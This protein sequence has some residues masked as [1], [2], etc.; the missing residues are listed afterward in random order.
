MEMVWTIIEIV[1]QWLYVIRKRQFRQK[2]IFKLLFFMLLVLCVSTIIHMSMKFFVRD[3]SWENFVNILAIIFFTISIFDLLNME[4]N[5]DAFIE[6]LLVYC[7]L[8]R[9]NQRTP[10]QLLKNII[11]GIMTI[12]LIYFM[13]Q[14]MNLIAVAMNLT[15]FEIAVVGLVIIYLVLYCLSTVGV[16]DEKSLY[17]NKAKISIALF[18]V[19]MIIYLMYMK[20]MSLNQNENIC[21]ILIFTIGQISFIQNAIDSYQ[22]AFAIMRRENKKEIDQYLE[23]NMESILYH[24]CSTQKLYGILSGKQL[25]M[26]DITKSNDYDEVYMFFPGLIDAMREEYYKKPFSFKFACEDNEKAML[27]FLRVIFNYFRSKFDRGGITNFVVCFC[28]KGDKLS[29]WRGYANN[30]KGVSIGFSERELAQYCEKYKE[31]MTMEK[32]KYKTA[33]EINNI[34]ISTAGLLLAE[35]KNL[36]DWIGNNF[37]CVD[38]ELE[39]YMVLFFT[40]MLS[41]VFMKSLQY[42]NKA[43]E[44]ENEWRIF[45]KYPILKKTEL[46][47]GGKEHDTVLVEE[48]V[49][50]LKNKID[51]NIMDDDIVAYF[52]IDLF[53]ISQN[54]I[55]EVIM[56]PNNQILQDDFELLCGK[57]KYDNVK[58]CYSN[59]PYRG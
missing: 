8:R 27:V 43:F 13:C 28:E 46:V 36:R 9:I 58:F 24:Y 41:G 49:E 4:T 14:E 32:I 22:S 2:N 18:F 55:K 48:M 31:V 45:F 17:M 56:G 5:K 53:D 42:K 35:L 34:I 57:Y 38:N 37:N 11:V 40:Q 30:G 3:I 7:Y 12:F 33:E 21:E 54:P 23:R 26:S 39:K 6:N 29:Q 44:E 20:D 10:K 16:I 25:R 59:I 15:L 50:V 52:P 19:L 47:Y 51:F 1:L